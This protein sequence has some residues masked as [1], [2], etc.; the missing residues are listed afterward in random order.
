VRQAADR[1][2]ELFLAVQEGAGE[3]WAGPYDETV[4]R[5]FARYREDEITQLL[6]GHGFRVR[7]RAANEAG[8]RRWLQLLSARD[9]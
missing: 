5:C 9:R 6:T 3:G 1:F 7:H 8:A 2:S 4:T